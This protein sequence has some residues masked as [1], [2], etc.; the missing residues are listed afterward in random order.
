M[1]EKWNF[2]G[3][4]DFKIQFWGPG[5]GSEGLYQ[6]KI[7][8]KHIL[9]YSLV[10][11]VQ[12]SYMFISFSM[13]IIDLQLKPI[14]LIEIPHFYPLFGGLLF[15]VLFFIPSAPGSWPH[16][17]PCLHQAG[18]WPRPWKRRVP[19]LHQ[20]N[21]LRNMF[22]YLLDFSFKNCISPFNWASK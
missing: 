3:V 16:G 22:Y 10:I 14:F 17:A 19:Q 13:K 18:I 21:D 15:I 8:F 20:S 6:S 11:P 7:D 4:G 1:D 12:I 2:G 5:R 9:N